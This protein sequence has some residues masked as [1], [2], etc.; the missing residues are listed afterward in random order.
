MVL[1]NT[2]IVYTDCFERFR[3]AS[4]GPS[5]PPAPAS[6]ITAPGSSSATRS[7]NPKSFTS[8]E[9]SPTATQSVSTGPLTDASTDQ[10][11]GPPVGAIVG[12]VIGGIALLGLLTFAFLFL[13]RRQPQ[14]DRT[15]IMSQFG[16]RAGNERP[17]ID[18][19]METK[20]PRPVI[21]SAPRQMSSTGK[22]PLSPPDTAAAA[23]NPSVSSHPMQSDSSFALSPSHPSD[24]P[25]TSIFAA[26]ASTTSSTGA[27]SPRNY[28][29]PA[30]SAAIAVPGDP[31]ESPTPANIAQVVPAMRNDI[32][33][34]RA[35]VRWLTANATGLSPGSS[36]SVAAAPTVEAPPQYEPRPRTHPHLEA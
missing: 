30:Q 14:K 10:S 9:G 33:D 2:W 6:G 34:L 3:L 21:A 22:M 4:A 5:Q 31:S 35:Q 19:Y 8:K 25:G 29:P 11:T 23:V 17:S 15:S 20:G 1:L 18:P 28:N 36:S 13:R 24:P 12:G 27:P 32:E 7:S 26:A 16:P